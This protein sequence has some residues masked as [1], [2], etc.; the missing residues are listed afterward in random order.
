MRYHDY[1]APES[2]EDAAELLRE[3]GTVISAGATDLIGELKG[4]ILTNPPEKVVSL[5]NIPGLRGISVEEDGL[6]IG[7]MTTLSEIERSEDVRGGWNALADAARSVATPNLRSTATI[8]GNICQDIRCWY[9]RYP[10]QIG[11]RIN[12]ARKDGSLCYAMRGENRYHSIFG[13]EKVCV[14]PCTGGCPSGTDIPGYMEQIRAG[15]WDKAARIIMQY[16]PFPMFTSRICPHPCQDK[17]NQNNY[18]DSVAIHSVERS[19]GDYIMEHMD[20]YYPAPATETGKSVAVIGAGPSGLTAAYYLRRAGHTVTVYDRMEKTGG[21]LRYGIP[22]YRLPKE[23]V[24]EVEKAMTAMGVEFRMGTEIGRDITVENIADRYDKVYLA[25]G[26]W[27]QPVIGL[28]GEE[29]TEFGLNFLVEVNTYLQKAIGN[30][31]LV[32]GGGNVAMDVALTAVRLGAKKVKLVCRKRKEDLSASPEELARVIE[33]G[34]EIY[35]C[36]GLRSVNTDENGKVTGLHTV[37][38][39]SVRGANG[40]FTTSY[41]EDDS[42]DISADYIIMATGQKVGLDFL[43]EKLASQL[44]TERGLIDAD[45]QTY[46]TK[47]PGIYAGGDVVT[48]PDIAIRAIKAGRMAAQSINR[49]LGGAVA[50]F[51]SAPLTKGFDSCGV[52]ESKAHPLPELPIG[53]RSLTR[54]DTGSYPKGEELAEAA[55]CFNCGCLAV[56]SSDVAT[57]LVAY[58]ATVKTNMRT[59]SAKDL[60]ATRT[61]IKD[62]LR[63]GEIVTEIIV[64]KQ[65]EGTVARYDKYRIRDSIDFAVTAVASVY[66]YAGG[67]VS[68]ASIVLGACAPVPHEAK[69]AEEYIVG[70]A[71]TE[72]HAKKLGELA[73]LGAIPLEHNAYKIDMT[74]V[75]VERSLDVK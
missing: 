24:D 14:T 53:E 21:V 45:K 4:D 52:T 66:T 36:R 70:K 37:R 29:L 43:G 74:R 27:K 6:H 49:A 10:D 28:G 65:P 19:L 25:T 12:C 9:Y 32:C 71:P 20:A 17:C 3:P 62:V 35:D 31:V 73:L 22:H 69:A 46:A 68:D 44:K 63:T 47:Y 67:V 40:K 50:E 2:L 42:L 39:Y 23:I 18:G 34:V 56:N 38:C 33:E 11:G 57:M 54:E 1:A 7:A 26:A 5:R 15:N 51:I 59:M 8:G 72:E 48:G 55:R 60:L 61:R 13:A 41:D 16:N 58:R 30:E 64:P 75:M